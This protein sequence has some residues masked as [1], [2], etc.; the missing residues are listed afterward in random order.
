MMF[1]I[2]PRLVSHEVAGL[3]RESSEFSKA[4]AGIFQSSIYRDFQLY[5]WGPFYL[6]IIDCTA[7]GPQL[8]AHKFSNIYTFPNDTTLEWT[9]DPLWRNGKENGCCKA[10]GAHF[11]MRKSQTESQHNFH[12]HCN[13]LMGHV[14]Y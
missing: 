1:T 6:S 9:V 5:L 10:T 12:S 14:L 4:A 3:Q 7:L 8:G 13:E 2:I 11:Q